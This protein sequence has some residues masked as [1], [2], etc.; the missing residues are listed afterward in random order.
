MFVR[1]LKLRAPEALASWIERPNV[2]SLLAP[3]VRVLSVVAGPGY[4]KTVLAAQ[5]FE[6]AKA[7]KAWYTFES[8][9]ADIGIFA[10][11]L[12]AAL[13]SLGAPP[14]LDVEVWRL[15]SAK[16]VGSYLAER[17]AS[18]AQG[19][20]FVFD[21]VHEIDGSPAA[22][23]LREVVLRAARV[24]ATFIVCGRAMPIPLH[25]IAARAQL[26]SVAPDDLLFDR[27]QT[28]ELIAR[29]TPG[30]AI[31][32]DVCALAA[33]ADGWPAGIAL[34]AST[35]N[36]AARAPLDFAA[37]GN[38]Q[39][40]QLLF[41]YLASEVFDRLGAAEGRLLLETA[42]LDSLE[43]ASCDA[44][45]GW[46]DSG[47]ILASLAERGVFVSRRSAH[48][49]TSHRLFREFL[50]H[51][52]RL[53]RTPAEIAELHGR[54][55]DEFAR[56]GDVARA[57]AHRLDAGTPETAADELE[58]AVLELLR[59]GAVS[60][61][62]TLLGRLPIERIERS[63]TLLTALGRVRSQAGDFDAASSALERAIALARRYGSYDIVAEAVRACAPI[64]GSRGA[65][66]RMRALLE[67]TL[68]LS[69]LGESS[70]TGLRMS[71]GALNVETGRFDEALEI[72]NAIMPIVV[73]RGDIGVH[74]SVL[75]NTAVAHLRRGDL[76]AGLS[77]YERA[78]ALKERAGQ[79]AS[80]L[81]TL[82]DLVYTRL[83]LG[84]LDEA[85]R[86]VADLIARAGDYGS[87]LTLARAYESLATLHLERGHVAAATL[88]F[89]EARRVCDPGDILVRP[90]ILHGLARCALA[91]RDLAS[92]DEGC[93]R[94]I[95][96]FR[97]AGR[98][99][100][101][102]PMLT[103]RALC[104]L[105]GDDAGAA[106]GFASAAIAAASEGTDAVLRAASYVDAAAL[107]LRAAERAG[108]AR[109]A[110]AAEATARA[111]ATEA[112]ALVY[113]RDYRFLLRT[114]AAAFAALQPLL[115][116]SDAAPAGAAPHAATGAAQLE[117]AMLG[118]FSV[119]V[120]G[121]TISGEWKRRKSRDIFAYI[122]SQRGRAVPR[123]KL[124]D[125][126]WPEMDAD[127]ANDALRVT[128]SAIRKAVGNV[129]VYEAGAYRFVSPAGTIV[130]V[131]LFDEAIERGRAALTRGEPGVAAAGF[132]A[133]AERYAGDF[134]EDVEDV[135]WEWRERERLR[136][137]A[138][139]A[140][141]WLATA[142][143][144]DSLTGRQARERLLSIAPFDLQAVVLQL[145]SLAEGSGAAVSDRA[146]SVWR[147]LY[148]TTVGAEAPNIWPLAAVAE[149]RARPAR[150]RF[151]DLVAR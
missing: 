22:A 43:T 7:P 103:T 140:L 122:V 115:R 130:D 15:G 78:F 137:A 3:D 100:Q 28:R 95:D 66:A 141:R 6:R 18:L 129:V 31:G 85:E 73:A 151:E 23:A 62:G 114:K 125:L 142:P 123:A 57:I 13:E 16:E 5:L 118:T 109:D 126:Y 38:Q 127:A 41:D 54:A 136:A 72:F 99:Q 68:T 112:L 134:L 111:A 10:S 29:A 80:A 55:A 39:T 44:I 144:V 14:I 121:R 32:D 90:Y 37:L 84:D 69:P 42:I 98:G 1:R 63:A 70:A 26:A 108:G 131:V 61:V 94:A 105:E 21:D 91:T 101:A 50:L 20:L 4:G 77:L 27:T 64:L 87:T 76:Y 11:H 83:L 2:E 47:R 93:A 59:V 86:V 49:Y 133:A 117:I 79:R 92:A 97:S 36:V 110:L 106:I 119:A 58:D 138:L 52:L 75:H 145:R 45:L 48:A 17:I 128:V 149:T 139:E 34:I 25:A 82:A 74:G 147:T 12:D 40:Q 132:V 51:E 102:A 67:E 9:D 113:Q 19:P 35:A 33:R 148:R 120:A 53:R 104:A 88:A 60:T 143:G 135:G 150:N 71:L 30:A 116:R 96:L 24:G 89:E 56:R 8:S 107:L 81:V 124:L 65:F 146:Y 46:D